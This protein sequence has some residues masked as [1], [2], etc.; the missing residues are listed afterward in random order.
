MEGIIDIHCHIIPGVDDGVETFEEC[1]KLLQMEYEQGVR[2]IVATPHFRRQ[3][4]ECPIGKIKEQYEKAKVLAK[5]VGIELVLGCEYHA[6]SAMIENL[7]S[8][9]CSTI[10]ETK[11]VLVEFSETSKFSFIREKVYELICN[12]YKPIVAH[13][14]RYMTLLDDMGKIE[15]LTELGVKIQLNAE[16]IIGL[17]GRKIKKFCKNMMKDNYMY[18]VGSDSHDI[19][20]RPPYMRR[21]ATYIEKK[22]GREYAR[23]VMIDNPQGIL[24]G[25]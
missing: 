18:V 22:I 21:C 5:E 25:D 14:E 13:A 17:E 8:K 16:S 10:G 2:T 3:M 24:A 15:E 4:F 9:L 23:K 7:K 12:G 19:R 1:R 6:D 20:R 11:Y